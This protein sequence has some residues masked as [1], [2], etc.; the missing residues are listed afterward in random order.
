MPQ[1]QSTS[2]TSKNADRLLINTYGEVQNIVDAYKRGAAEMHPS[3]IYKEGYWSDLQADL[4]RF[5]KTQQNQ[6]EEHGFDAFAGELH[7]YQ[8][9]VIR[10][11]VEQFRHRIKEAPEAIHSDEQWKLFKQDLQ[12]SSIPRQFQH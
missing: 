9:F 12:P 5:V 8:L 2:S 10:S 3:I 7:H 11:A 4:E 6:F 1:Q